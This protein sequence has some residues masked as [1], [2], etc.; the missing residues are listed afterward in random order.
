[1][2]IHTYIKELRF[3][4][5][6]YIHTYKNLGSAWMDPAA[7]SRV[8]VRQFMA[9]ALITRVPNGPSGGLSVWADESIKL[10]QL[11]IQLNFKNVLYKQISSFS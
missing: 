7:I 10:V 4:M 6:G 8:S 1:L 5:D 11:Q 3:C 9:L 2:Y